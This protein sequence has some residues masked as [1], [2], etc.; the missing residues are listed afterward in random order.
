[1]VRQLDRQAIGEVE[2]DSGN[3]D[4]RNRQERASGIQVLIS[5]FKRRAQEY[6]RWM[7]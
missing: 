5:T 4:A 7:V 6:G 3:D 2:L 1:M